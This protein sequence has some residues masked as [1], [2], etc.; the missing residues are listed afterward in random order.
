MKDKD[1][2]RNTADFL[3]DELFITWRLTGDEELEEYWNEYLA[4]HPEA[5][6]PFSEAAGWF[7]K[8]HIRLKTETLSEADKSGLLKRIKQPARRG[9]IAFI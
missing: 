2:L 3:K 6:S 1:L 4:R 5:A 8:E 9:K 7:N